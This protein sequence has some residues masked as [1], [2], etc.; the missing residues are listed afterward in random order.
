MWRWR[1]RS[2]FY[3]S[4]RSLIRQGIFISAAAAGYVWNSHKNKNPDTIKSVSNPLGNSA[5]LIILMEVRF[6]SDNTDGIAW[7]R[8][9]AA[10]EAITIFNFLRVISN[11]DNRKTMGIN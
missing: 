11:A 10:T 9:R 2:L 8:A 5:Q 7:E 6:A 3:A 1:S 4:A